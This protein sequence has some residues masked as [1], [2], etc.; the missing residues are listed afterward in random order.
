[1][2]GGG[3]ARA[4]H[5]FS[6]SYNERAVLT[7]DARLVSLTLKNPHSF[8]QVAVSTRGREEIRYLVE[9][10]GQDE[11]RRAGIG[12]ATFRAGDR[13]I[14][15]GQPGRSRSDYRLRLKTLHRPK[16]GLRWTESMF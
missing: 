13:I 10:G 16:D 2:A 9:W 5:D 12:G 8:M 6:P 3:S 14:L 4:H 15:T 11:L 1:M 7:I